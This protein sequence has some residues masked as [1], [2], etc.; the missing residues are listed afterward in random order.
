M[1][2]FEGS[3]IIASGYSKL[4]VTCDLP[5]HSLC[6]S[7][8]IDTPKYTITSWAADCS[9]II[10]RDLDLRIEVLHTPGHTPDSLALWCD[11]DKMLFVGDTLYE[12][13]PTIFPPQ[14]DIVDWLGSMDKLREYVKEKMAGSLGKDQFVTINCGHVTAGQPALEVLEEMQDFMEKVLGGKVPRSAEESKGGEKYLTYGGTGRFLVTCP[15]RLI[16]EAREKLEL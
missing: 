8:G 9:P 15:E 3:T 12:Y 1:P 2:Q 4:F 10:Y 16:L 7:L 5:T 6:K 11:E 14:G 13:A